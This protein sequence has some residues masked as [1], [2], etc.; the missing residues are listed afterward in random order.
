[1]TTSNN[2]Q[3]SPW[4]DIMSRLASTESLG[5]T[6]ALAQLLPAP[7]DNATVRVAQTNTFTY[8]F[9]SDFSVDRPYGTGP[10]TANDGSMHQSVLFKAWHGGP[11]WDLMNLVSLAMLGSHALKDPAASSQLKQESTALDCLVESAMF[12]VVNI[13][14]QTQILEEAMQRLE[15]ELDGLEASVGATAPGN[16]PS[17]ISARLGPLHVILDEKTERTNHGIDNSLR[18]IRESMA[19]TTKPNR[20]HAHGA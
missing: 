18:L 14:A 8:R 3:P 10:I 9:Q 4:L 7:A 12:A 15:G 13:F 1:M 19:N 11:Y 6:S 16:T 17:D 2:E 20:R 5:H